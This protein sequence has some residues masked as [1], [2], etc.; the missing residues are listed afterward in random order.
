[1]LGLPSVSGTWDLGP[2]VKPPLA[3]IELNFV[4]IVVS[5]RNLTACSC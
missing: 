1:M 2:H 3:R 5:S 4:S